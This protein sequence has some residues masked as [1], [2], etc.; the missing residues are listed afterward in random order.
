M[1]R[2]LSPEQFHNPGS[3]AAGL[4]QQMIIDGVN[5]AYRILDAIDEQLLASG[6]PRLASMV[7]LANLSAIIG[8]FTAS[9]IV[10]ASA[11]VF[12][13]AGPHK[14]QDLRAAG[15]S[16][17]H[18]NIEIKVA[19]ETNSPKG[20]LAKSGYYLTCRYVLCDE[21]GRCVPGERGD[22]P[23]IWELRFGHL[24]PDHFALSNTPGDSGKTA[25]VNAQGMA[26]LTLIYFDGDRCP[27]GPRSRYVRPT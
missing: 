11:G 16:T 7:E 15:L 17:D 25:V 10:Q 2:E 1:R 21:A 13:R 24:E 19:L 4:S 6:S 14:Y 20:H 18:H 8:N 22:V 3:L 12:T 5:T 23:W 9:G 27:F 26:A